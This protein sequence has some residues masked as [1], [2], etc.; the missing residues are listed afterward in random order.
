MFVKVLTKLATYIK[1]TLDTKIV[2]DL[3]KEL[4]PR[5]RYLEIKLSEI[6]S[7]CPL[8]KDKKG[9]QSSPLSDSET[10]DICRKRYFGF[11]LQS[12]VGK[13][14]NEETN[15]LYSYLKRCEDCSLSGAGSGTT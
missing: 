11:L 12:F 6:C 4:L 2:K 5:D 1:R 9:H 15:W 7:Q 14:G 8:G 3:V 13:P 10:I